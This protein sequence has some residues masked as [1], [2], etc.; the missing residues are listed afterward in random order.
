MFRSILALLVTATIL[1][2]SVSA[3]TVLVNLATDGTGGRDSAGNG[4]SAT[5][6]WDDGGFSIRWDISENQDGTYHYTYWFGGSVG[7]DSEEDEGGEGALEKGLSHWNL[8]VSD[9]VGSDAFSG[10]LEQYV[11]DGSEIGYDDTFV[12]DL[13][14]HTAS[15][16]NPGMP[17]D[18]YGLKW[19]T[20]D[21]EIEIE[22]DDESTFE[23]LDAREAHFEFDSTQAP[24]WGN[25]YANSGGGHD[26]D[27]AVFAHNDG[28][29][30]MPTASTT[31]F[32][33]WI[34]RPDGD[35]PVAVPVPAAA[36]LGIALL[37]LIGA[38]RVARCAQKLS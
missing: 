22:G 26:E 1:A 7:E 2:A 8:Q 16:G 13:A 25:F 14:T 17:A 3:D 29:L 35:L 12:P 21:V 24:V 20:P 11:H 37:A 4:V 15:H 10:F 38:L 18:L 27:K 23:T 28:F 31:D 30:S 6:D 19:D 32:T 5:H 36:P 33:A 9:G 34:P